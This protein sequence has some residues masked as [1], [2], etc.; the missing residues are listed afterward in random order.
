M[1]WGPGASLTAL[2]VPR[3]RAVREVTSWKGE[4]TS[5]PPSQMPA[6]AVFL[7]LAAPQVCKVLMPNTSICPSAGPGAVQPRTPTAATAAGLSPCLVSPP[8]PAAMLRLMSP[9]PPEGLAAGEAVA[10]GAA[11]GGF[12]SPPGSAGAE[13]PGWAGAPPLPRPCC[14]SQC[15]ALPSFPPGLN[16][17]G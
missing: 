13:P 8:S 15:S 5:H 17:P 16:H 3:L 14:C 2:V 6:V 11:D 4:R 7:P 1:G 9:P 12:H 10:P